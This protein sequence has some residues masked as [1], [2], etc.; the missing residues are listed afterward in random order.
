VN[1][2]DVI[3][4]WLEDTGLGPADYLRKCDTTGAATG[5]SIFGTPEQEWRP[6]TIHTDLPG[7]QIKVSIELDAFD[8][9]YEEGSIDDLDE[10]FRKEEGNYDLP[11]HKYVI[12][13]LADEGCF[14][15]ISVIREQGKDAQVDWKHGE[16]EV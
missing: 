13:D 15:V 7:S 14:D 8:F 5:F 9:G 1:K 12:L 16:F 3:R 4:Q 6:I 10:D 11:M 2:V